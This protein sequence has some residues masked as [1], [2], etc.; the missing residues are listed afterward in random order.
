MRSLIVAAALLACGC[1]A[2]M[3]TTVDDCARRLGADDSDARAKAARRLGEIGPAAKTAVPA[4]TAA[5]RDQ[6][7]Y[8]RFKAAEALGKI[9]RDARSAVPELK[10]LRSDPEKGVQANAWEALKM[11]G[12]SGPGEVA[13]AIPAAPSP[14]STIVQPEQPPAAVPAEGTMAVL[15]LAA[16]GVEESEAAVI[17]DM[18]RSD[19]VNTGVFRIVEKQNMEKILA[20]QAFQKTGCTEQDCAVKVGRVLNVRRM[21]VGSCGRLMSRFFINVRVVD[22]ESGEIKFADGI[23]GDT[24]DDLESGLKVLASKISEKAR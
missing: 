16:Q 12:D 17:S 19:L 4:L 22:V 3:Q 24:T 5:L 2:N 18:L 14:S 6:S 13:A 11:I 7:P 9:G 20:E 15:D 8:V 21:V 23:K 10:R 1:A